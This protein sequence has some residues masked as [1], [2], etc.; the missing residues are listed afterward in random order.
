MTSTS[1]WIKFFEAAGIPSSISLTYAVAFHDNRI[2]LNI[3]GDLNKV[4]TKTLKSH[5]TKFKL[6]IINRLF[7]QFKMK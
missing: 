1:E 7:Y 6:L 4:C 2:S 3:L 5:L